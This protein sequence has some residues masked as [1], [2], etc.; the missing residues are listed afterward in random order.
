MSVKLYGHRTKYFSFML[1]RVS[2][3]WIIVPTM[4]ISPGDNGGCVC[5]TWLCW[6]IGVSVN[7][8]I[9]K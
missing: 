2:H 5:V 7:Y 1:N 9:P 3:L 6:V 8:V 4:I